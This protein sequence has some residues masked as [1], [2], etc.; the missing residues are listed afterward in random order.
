MTRVT[1]KN[2]EGCRHR[3]SSGMISSFH[4]GIP[5]RMQHDQVLERAWQQNNHSVA[6]IIIQRQDHTPPNVANALHGL[7]DA[8]GAIRGL[9][10]QPQASTEPRSHFPT[11]FSSAGGAENLSITIIPGPEYN[12]R[13]QYSSDE[14]NLSSSHLFVFN[15]LLHF[16]VSRG[17][18]RPTSRSESSSSSHHE[19]HMTEEEIAGNVIFSSLAVILNM[20][21]IL[22]DQAIS[23]AS[24]CEQ[25]HPEEQAS[26]SGHHSCCLQRAYRMYQLVLESLNNS[27]Y[28]GLASSHS[29]SLLMSMR[30]IAMNNM[31]TIGASPHFLRTMT[32][33]SHA[34]HHQQQSSTLQGLRVCLSHDWNSRIPRSVESGRYQHAA[35]FL[36]EVELQQMELNCALLSSTNTQHAGLN[37]L[38]WRAAAAA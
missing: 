38:S 24:A 15:R 31:A 12:P 33:E 36:T 8:L 27:A 10:Q 5:A 20:A 29:T 30:L 14:D 16:H 7:R 18:T 21:M 28:I 32:S 2:E 22:Q 26:R 11:S 3:V 25:Q 6:T 34:A 23:A 19:D 9:L 17:G 37:L 4:A 35:T 1:S 13:N